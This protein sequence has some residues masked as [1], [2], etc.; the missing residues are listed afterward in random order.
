VNNWSDEQTDDPLYADRRNLYKIEKWE[1]RR[2]LEEATGLDVVAGAPP[3]NR[4]H[5]HLAIRAHARP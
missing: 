1:P 3:R 4:P 5:I 2:A